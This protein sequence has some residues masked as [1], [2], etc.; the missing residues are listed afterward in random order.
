MHG[1]P[2]PP[3][4]AQCVLSNT[5]ISNPCMQG[6]KKPAPPPL[7]TQLPQ[8]QQQQRRLHPLRAGC[9][10]AWGG[11]MAWQPA[12]HGSKSTEGTTSRYWAR[13]VCTCAYMCVCTRMCVCDCVTV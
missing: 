13:C 1:I 8:Q 12:G 7:L 9:C 5:S 3:Y 10:R 2:P 4:R 11:T 6:L